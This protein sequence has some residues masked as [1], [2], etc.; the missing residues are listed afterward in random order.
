MKR[1]GILAAA[2]AVL[3]SACGG[4]YGAK[5]S[6]ID[7]GFS[8]EGGI[9]QKGPLAAGSKVSIDELIS[10]T[11]ASAGAS[12]NLQ[13]TG[14]LGVFD[15][16]ALRLTRQH[17][18]TYVS[19]YYRNELTGDLANDQVTL[20]A[21]S[22]LDADRL[23]NVNLLTT[24]AAPRIEKLVRDAS[25]TSTYRKFGAARAQAQKEVLAAF[26]IYN[27]ADLMPGGTDSSQSIVAGSFNELDLAKPQMSSVVLAALSAVAVKAGGNGAGIS[28]FI[29]DFQTD[30]AAD[31]LINQAAVR[32]QIDAA[33]ATTDMAAVATHLKKFFP[34][35]TVTA[36]QLS[37]WVDSSGGTDEVI[38]KYKFSASN[39]G[40]ETLAK[41]PPYLV[42]PDDANQCFSV[43]VPAETTASISLHYNGAKISSTTHQ[44]V[45]VG[46]K[47]MVGIKASAAGENTA[48]LQRST[49][50][51]NGVCPTA[52]SN[53]VRVLKYTIQSVNQLKGTVT[54]LGLGKSVS[55]SRKEIGFQNKVDFD[56]AADLVGFEGLVSAGI[57]NDPVTGIQNPVAKLVKGPLGRPY[58]GAT[59]FTIKDGAST[60]LPAFDLAS[61][62][63]VTV[64]S[65][66]SAPPGT[67][68][69]LKL[70]NPLNS[71]AN[72]SAQAATTVRDAWETL[73]FDFSSGSTG[74]TWGAWSPLLTYNMASLFPGY[75]MKNGAANPLPT[76]NT[77]F[78][79]DDLTYAAVSGNLG[80]DTL[81][82]TV[83]ISING[84]FS[85][86][87]PIVDGSRYR[88]SV[89]TPPED[90]NCALSNADFVARGEYSS[91]VVNCT[92]ASKVPTTLDGR[93]LL[94]SD[95]FNSDGLPDSSK[96]N[97]DT[98]RNR[99][100]WYNNELQ[101]YASGRL[102]NSSVSSGVLSV[103]AIRERLSS[104]QDYGN[105]NFSS[106]RLITRG[107]F[108]FT[109]GFVEVSAKLPCS[110]GTW[111][112]I[113]MLG[114]SAGNW[115]DIG[116]I[117]ILEQRG[118]NND[119]KKTVLATLHMASN[120]G[121]NGITASK[122]LPDA[123]TAFH[124]YQ[125]TWTPN[126]ISLGV[127][128]TV[129]NTYVKP[130]NATNSNWPFDKPQ[131]LLLNLAIGGDLG[132]T[133][134]SSFLTDRMEVEY[135]RVYQ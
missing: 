118:F 95:E 122:A 18:K 33:S 4:G 103:T 9:A 45:T 55:L 112:A 41:S 69:S 100:G 61:E 79:F 62:K 66:T 96:W 5:V 75:S 51:T 2:T 106:A 14:D 48:Y 114:A 12:Y 93:T 105:Q 53:P 24:L 56:G 125:L 59:V 76:T 1:L 107:K 128:G 117:D 86:P 113:W 72:I 20:M 29:A 124:K 30:L 82:D 104:L 85:F 68:I 78:Y 27:S 97:Y 71:S 133:V 80:V 17:I 38:D 25:S 11:F 3:L 32:S 10:S 94:W 130:M 46:D 119:E 37:P 52:P 39:V 43:I 99:V 7:N 6:K 36:A 101:Y 110:V 28:E 135:V 91:L 44:K 49:P 63:R 67:V 8:V 73:T 64:R 134:P 57:V 54:G 109:Y 50:K 42:G 60:T 35:T 90:Q 102:Q 116:E 15:T 58:A 70:E 81:D 129:Y 131:F 88:V 126:Q 111:P 89:A 87:K 65:Y 120:F 74:L 127:D 115:P 23:V 123:C 83:S 121:G 16:S 47:L 19:G 31:G 84:D 13:T 92:D 132:G 34:S 26:R 98:E 108:S 77:A 22:D 40:T 21:Y